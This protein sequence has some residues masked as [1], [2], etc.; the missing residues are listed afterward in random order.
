MSTAMEK[1]SI[2]PSRA[3]SLSLVVLFSS[4]FFPPLP[5]AFFTNRYL[6]SRL[7]SRPLS[8]L[9]IFLHLSR[10]VFVSSRPNS[11]YLVMN[12]CPRHIKARRFSS[13]VS[14]SIC[15]Y[16]IERGRERETRGKQTGEAAKIMKL[17]K[18]MGTYQIDKGARV[19]REGRGVGIPPA[20]WFADTRQERWTEIGS[21]CG[22][23]VL[24]LSN[25]VHCRYDT[26]KQ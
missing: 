11:S 10:P 12:P 14:K 8:A 5:L 24:C 15:G 19:R 2:R 23:V 17:D 7:V 4:F 18:R 6:L 25:Q 1:Q 20:L 22:W 16:V 13:P 3:R 21:A 26:G 9:I